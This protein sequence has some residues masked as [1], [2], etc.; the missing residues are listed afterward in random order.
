MVSQICVLK[1]FLSQVHLKFNVSGL[2]SMNSMPI[3]S[4]VLI[5]EKGQSSIAIVY[6]RKPV[7]ILKNSLLYSPPHVFF[8]ISKLYWFL[9]LDFLKFPFHHPPYLFEL[10]IQLFYLNIFE[11]YSQFS[12]SPPPIALPTFQ[13]SYPYW[14]YV[15]TL[16]PFQTSD[17]LRCFSVA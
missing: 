2:K 4:R 3:T 10:H 5:S 9:S 12:T 7:L 11:M 14:R 16:S 17:R 15:F 8:F 1:L 13:S 6:A